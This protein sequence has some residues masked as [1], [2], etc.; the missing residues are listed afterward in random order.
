[1]QFTTN[2]AAR[3]NGS[4]IYLVEDLVMKKWRFDYLIVINDTICRGSSRQATECK[5]DEKA[6]IYRT[7]Y[8]VKPLLD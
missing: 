2:K 7:L 1:L 3:L 5:I 6:A 8:C 4:F